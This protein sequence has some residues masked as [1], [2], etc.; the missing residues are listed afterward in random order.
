M[1]GFPC[2]FFGVGTESVGFEALAVVV[3][4]IF[5]SWDVSPY[6]SRR[7]G[8]TCHIHLELKAIELAQ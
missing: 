6:I 5:I 4:K 1:K 2:V 3:M 7:F 8:G